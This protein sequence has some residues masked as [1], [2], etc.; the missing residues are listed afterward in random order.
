MRVRLATML[1]LSDI[2]AFGK[3]AM[4]KSN[5]AQFPFNSVIA[6]KIGKGM[7]TSKDSRVWVAET[8]GG[9]LTGFLIGEV[10]P[11]PFTHYYSAT[12]LLFVAD[13]G[14]DLL[15]DAFVEWCKLKGV[16]R[17]DMGVSAGPEREEAVRRAFERKGFVYSGPMFH[18]NMLPEGESK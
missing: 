9:K 2:V 7:M 4:E 14:G 12:D 5:Y 10:G 8:D 3:A 13:Q 15:L 18:M 17:I 11:M 16:A 1:D 6:R